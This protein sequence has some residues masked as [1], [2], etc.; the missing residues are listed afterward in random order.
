MVFTVFPMA[1]IS[2][3]DI[4]AW[5]DQRVREPQKRRL[6]LAA[7]NAFDRLRRVR[8]I[9]ALDLSPIETAAKCPF[10]AVWI[11]GTDLIMRLAAK[12]RVAKDAVRRIMS[13]KKVEERFQITAAL[14][15]ILPKAFSKEIIRIALKDKGKRVR[16]KAVEACDRLRLKEML[17]ELDARLA[18]EHNPDV[19][20]QLQFSIA[21]LREGYLLEPE[22]PCLIVTTPIGFCCPVV[23]KKDITEERLSAL[24]S[25]V[26]S[27]RWP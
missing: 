26:K 10:K 6:L 5:V 2:T 13:S 27:G 18:V 1:S 3:R 24:I 4:R 11:I 7:L 19:K 25:G 17:P 8:R 23:T 22:E 16:E 9:S 20:R 21:M 14:T 12:D 15:C